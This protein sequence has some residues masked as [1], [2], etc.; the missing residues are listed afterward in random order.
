DYS[1]YTNSQ[2]DTMEDINDLP[3]KTVGQAAVRVR[4]IGEAKD[5][6]QIQLNVVRVDGQ[7]S[8][9]LPILKQGGGANTIAVVDGTKDA[10]NNLT[11]VPKALRTNVVFDQSLF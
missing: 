9:Y 2:L 1:I 3:I 5:A 7:N 8:V 10:V 11:G 6:Q 4:D